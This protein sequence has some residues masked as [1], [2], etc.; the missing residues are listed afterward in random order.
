M[1]RM[2][3][4]WSPKRKKTGPYNFGQIHP[5]S[6]RPCMEIFVKIAHLFKELDFFSFFSGFLKI[7]VFAQKCKKMVIFWD[8]FYHS[9]KQEHFERNHFTPNTTTI[10]SITG[11]SFIKISPRFLWRPVRFFISKGQIFD[12][13][14]QMPK[15]L[16]ACS[17]KRK[18]TERYNFSQINLATYKCFVKNFVY[19]AQVFRD[20]YFLTFFFIFV[21]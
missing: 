9:P 4:A 13:N 12:Q 14:A 8:F 6:K 18:K 21:T 1:A 11:E 20:L 7:L 2:S 10:P 3:E 16:E 5:A 15:M 17:P 19:T